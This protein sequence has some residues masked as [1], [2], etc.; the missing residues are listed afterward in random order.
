MQMLK[1]ATLAAAGLF[2][3][4]ACTDDTKETGLGESGD[5]YI[6]DTIIQ[7][8]DSSCDASSWS[9]SA[10]TDGWTS[11]AVLNID[12]TGVDP[13]VAWDEEHT[14]VST[15][16]DPNGYW[17]TVEIDLPIVTDWEQ[18]QADVNTL[19]Q[20][21]DDRKATLT[22][23]IRVWDPDGTMSDC[24]VWGDDPGFYASYGCLNWN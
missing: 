15:D 11:D 5:V 24:A 13:S 10:T 9:F 23:M 12:Q 7:Q 2:A 3:M 16:Y 14:L 1:I 21:N 4:T 8:I 19:F 22:W 17:D 20:C 6:G 18:Q